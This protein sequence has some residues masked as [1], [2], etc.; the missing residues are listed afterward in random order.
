M[1]L[2]GLLPE[3]EFE[4]E[5]EN[6]V[7][8]NIANRGRFWSYYLRITALRELSVTCLAW[9]SLHPRTLTP[10]FWRPVAILED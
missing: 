6:D 10:N 9:M 5:K 1:T 8:G 2:S 3:K 4:P 7:D